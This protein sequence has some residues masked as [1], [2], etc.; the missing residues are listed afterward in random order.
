MISKALHTLPLVLYSHIYS[1]FLLLYIYIGLLSKRQPGLISADMNLITMF[2]QNLIS[3]DQRVKPAIQDGLTMMCRAFEKATHLHEKIQDLL[4][5]YI[6]KSE[7]QARFMAVY[8]A[9]RLFK[10]D[11]VPARYLCLLAVDDN[12][13]EVK[14]EASRYVKFIYV[15]VYSYFFY[16]GLRPF[17]Q[18]DGDIIP[19]PSQPYP[20]FE[21]LV[22]YI[23]QLTSKRLETLKENTSGKAELVHTPLILTFLPFQLY[24]PRVHEEILNFLRTTFKVSAT[25]HEKDMCA[26]TDYLMKNKKSSIDEYIKLLDS[27]IGNTYLM[28]RFLPY[29][30]A[31]SSGRGDLHHRASTSL[32]ELIS[33][34]PEQISSYYVSKFDWLKTFLFAGAYESREVVARILGLVSTY[35]E[36]AVPTIKDLL[37]FTLPATV[38]AELS[39][40]KSYGSANALGFIISRHLQLKKELPKELIVDALWNLYHLLGH[41]N[42]LLI[43]AAVQAIGMYIV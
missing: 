1:S 6:D 23:A 15:F 32:L 20:A 30:T 34:Q 39:I 41:V 22:L 37:A 33:Y 3:E 13:L 2:F 27:G 28:S 5:E 8:Y 4:L 14:E 24:T 35:L 10:F 43:G 26:Y 31:V 40:D 38:T 16:R 42:T 19:D 12:K 11:S 21:D 25:V 9:N 17:I 36:S 29:H 18:K 7:Y